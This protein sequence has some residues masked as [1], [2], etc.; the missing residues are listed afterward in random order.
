MAN[1]GGRASAPTRNRLSGKKP[2]RLERWVS[3]DPE[4]AVLIGDL[5]QRKT[6]AKERLN[7]GDQ[8]AESQIV[9]IED[10][11]SDILSEHRESLIKF[12]AVAAGAKRWEEL[13][14]EHT[15]TADQSKEFRKRTKG[16]QALPWNTDTFPAAALKECL[17]IADVDDDLKEI[18]LS[19]LTDE[20]IADLTENEGSDDSLWN[21]AE[22]NE[23]F[24]LVVAVNMRT[25]HL[26]DLGNGS[27]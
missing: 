2:Q 26:G 27:R 14:A 13:K 10:E 25:G 3:L 18:G 6:F 24:N 21:E 15:P 8:T 5:N 17:R 16:L 20:E 23:L 9:A 1:K 19:E 11:I 12:V 7:Q 22:Q 4:V